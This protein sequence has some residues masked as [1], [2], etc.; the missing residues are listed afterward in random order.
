MMTAQCNAAA[1]EPG[2]FDVIPHYERH[3]CSVLGYC[4]SKMV[5]YH[6]LH[7]CWVIVCICHVLQDAGQNIYIILARR[8]NIEC[9]YHC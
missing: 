8:L 5:H 3:T 1:N 9:V 2:V 4:S 6:L 7:M